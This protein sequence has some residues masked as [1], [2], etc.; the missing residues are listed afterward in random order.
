MIPTTLLT[1]TTSSF[2]SCFSSSLDSMHSWRNFLLQLYGF[3]CSTKQTKMRRNTASEKEEMSTGTSWKLTTH[4]QCVTHFI[5][6]SKIINFFLSPAGFFLNR[7]TFKHKHDQI[8]RTC[9]IR[10]IKKCI[11]N[12]RFLQKDSRSKVQH[13]G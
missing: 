4:A 7:V 10:V 11:I 9:A 3:V 6:C 8:F 2:I 5:W 12:W 13:N 1:F